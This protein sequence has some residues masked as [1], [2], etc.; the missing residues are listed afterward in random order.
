MF[1]SQR[2][3][4]VQP[5]EERRRGAELRLDVHRLVAV[6]RVHERLEVELSPVRP[7]KAC[8]SVARPLHRR[9]D[10]VAVA[11]VHVVAHSDLVPVIED[12]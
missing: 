9:P 6:H 3:E 10:A 4:P 1:L 5:A 2:D 11:E 7:R 12:R 8:I